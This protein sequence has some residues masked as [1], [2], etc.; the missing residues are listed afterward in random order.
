MN[1]LF[2]LILF[3]YSA[4]TGYAQENT[5]KIKLSL[6]EAIKI[7]S[8][9][10]PDATAAVKEI[11]AA[12]GKILQAGRLQN[13]ELSLEANEISSKFDLGETGELDISFNQPF[14]FF[15]KRNVRIQ[16]AELQKKIAEL[17][18]ERTRKLITA[19]VKK[20]YYSGLLSNRIVQSIE[21]NINL[22]ND[23]LSQVTDRYQAGTSSYLD[24]IRAKV[25]IARLKNELF[26][27]MKNYQQVTGRLKTILGKENNIEYMLTDSLLYRFP[28][29][30]KDTVISF[31][32]SQ[33]SF[34]RIY[35]IQIEQNKLFLSLAEKNS[36]PDFNFGLAF[37]NRQSSLAGGFDQYLGLNV[38]VSLPMFYSSGVQGD[39]HEAEANLSISDIRYKYARIRTAQS[40]KT[41]FSNLAFA[42]EQ[43][44]L[45]DTSL[46][47]DVGDELSAGITAY[48]NGQIDLLNLFDIYRTY[49][50]TGVEYSS[51]VYNTLTAL[52]DLE[53]SSEVV[54]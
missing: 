47:R 2:V 35:E 9:N 22:L 41:A 45:F 46:L 1:K 25:E 40:I 44:R 53:I 36:L 54:E 3:V 11:D 32:S 21:S 42:E 51:T 18:Y 7:A 52:V 37:Q 39:I 20:V 43:L 15:S 10:N 19:Q 17:N 31:Y 29:L 14:E 4:L 49:R 23:F 38:G 27:A 13:A 12:G 48:Q 34:L 16:A 28:E 50:S 6:N 30:N 8:E 26:D 24:V 33:S 5:D